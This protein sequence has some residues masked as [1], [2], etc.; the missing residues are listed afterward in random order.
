MASQKRKQVVHEEEEA[1]SDC[2]VVQTASDHEF[3]VEIS[4][5]LTGKRPR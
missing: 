2:L 1:D 5:A 4:G 3:D